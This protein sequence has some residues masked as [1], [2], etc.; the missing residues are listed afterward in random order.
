MKIPYCEDCKEWYPE[1]T[2]NAEQW[3]WIARHSMQGHKITRRE[4]RTKK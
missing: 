1:N 3:S 2:S 4:K